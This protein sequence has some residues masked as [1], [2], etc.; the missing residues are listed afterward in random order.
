MRI[1]EQATNFMHTREH[2]EKISKMTNEL[3]KPSYTEHQVVHFHA[4]E[5]EALPT[6]AHKQL[7]S[8]VCDKDLGFTGTLEA[9][10]DVL[11][12]HIALYKTTINSCDNPTKRALATANLRTLANALAQAKSTYAED[13][14]R[15]TIKK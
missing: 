10:V 3:L 13:L 15:L 4:T 6:F 5:D 9:L 14:A 8:L 11:E 2:I 7:H 1:P 12:Y